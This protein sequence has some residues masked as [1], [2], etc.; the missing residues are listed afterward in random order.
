MIEHL[1]LTGSGGIRLH[2]AA[3]G[4]GPLMLLLHGFPEC[5]HAWHRQLDVFARTHRVVALDLR[6]YNR[7]D[8]P[9][10]VSSYALPHIVDDLRCVLSEL[11]PSDPAVIVG[12]DWGGI[13]AWATA[14]EFPQSVHRLVVINA[15]HPVIFR[16]LLTSSLSQFLASSYAGFFQLRGISEAALRAFNFAALRFMIYGTS[17]CPGCFPSELREAYLKA[18][19]QP[20]A[21]TAGLSYYRNVRSLNNLAKY[22]GDWVI[23]V[24]TLVLWGERDPAL[25]IANL[26]GLGDYVPRLCLKRHPQATHWIVHEHPDWVNQTIA[27]YLNRGIA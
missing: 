18:W 9:P 13:A 22:A 2:A 14:R 5:W 7:S 24:P 19:R 17:S 27:E 20:G 23:R 11:S 16:R 8:K 4:N 25:R 21:L 10:G 6:G 15:P 26:D 1:S 3:A 12:H